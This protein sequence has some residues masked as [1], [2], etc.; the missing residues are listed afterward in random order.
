MGEALGKAGD[1]VDKLEADHEAAEHANRIASEGREVDRFRAE[2]DRLK[3]VLPYLTP[4]AVAEIAASVGL[5][6]AS[7]PD[8]A[9][10]PQAPEPEA[11]QEYA[12]EQPIEQQEP[13]AEAAEPPG[14]PEPQPLEQAPQ[15]AFFTPEQP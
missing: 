8:I 11:A 10:G 3:L 1:H 15:G 6:A 2:T 12:P 7:T 5:Q 13:Q 4:Q 14:M 9:T